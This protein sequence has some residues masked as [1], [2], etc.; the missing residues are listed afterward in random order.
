MIPKRDMDTLLYSDDIDITSMSMEQQLGF[1][2]DAKQKLSNKIE[3][4]RKVLFSLRE[5]IVVSE[6]ELVQQRIENS[7]LV[8]ET[9]RRLDKLL[10]S[11][12]NETNFNASHRSGVQHACD[13]QKRANQILSLCQYFNF[14]SAKDSAA[15]QENLEGISCFLTEQRNAY[16]QSLLY[17]PAEGEAHTLWTSEQIE[18]PENIYMLYSLITPFF[19]VPYATTTVQQVCSLTT[20]LRTL[21][22]F[23]LQKSPSVL[24]GM[25]NISLLILWWKEHLVDDFSTFIGQLEKRQH[26]EVILGTLSNLAGQQDWP[27]S[28]LLSDTL[29][30]MF[31]FSNLVSEAASLSR[32]YD[33]MIENE[34]VW[35][36]QLLDL[37]FSS[38]FAS[39]E[40]I[41]TSFDDFCNRASAYMKDSSDNKPIVDFIK[42]L[43]HTY[44]AVVYRERLILPKIFSRQ[45][46][47]L[48]KWTSRFHESIVIR[49]LSRIM[50]HT[51]I[52][53]RDSKN[54]TSIQTEATNATGNHLSEKGQLDLYF[55]TLE[56]VLHEATC[57]G[58]FVNLV[59]IDGE[60]FLQPFR[61]T[62]HQFQM[63]YS[64]ESS[65]FLF[66]NNALQFHIGDML[67]S[68]G[69]AEQFSTKIG[70]YLNDAAKSILR[71]RVLL[72]AEYVSKSL[73][74]S[75][76][77]I[78][79]S[80]S[81]IVTH[82]F[83]KLKIN[84]EKRV[85]SLLEMVHK[86]T[87]AGGAGL[88]SSWKVSTSSA[89]PATEIEECSFHVHEAQTLFASW[90]DSLRIVSRNLESFFVDNNCKHEPEDAQPSW[91][92]LWKKTLQRLNED[93]NSVTKLF[94]Y[95][96]VTQALHHLV[97]QQSKKD[98]EGKTILPT[99]TAACNYVCS[100][101]RKE[102]SQFPNHSQSMSL[103]YC[104]FLLEGLYKGLTLHV[105]NVRTSEAG[106]RALR[107]D[108]SGYR[109]FAQEV[110]NPFSNNIRELENEKDRVL[111]SF[112]ALFHVKP[113]W[114]T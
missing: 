91:M 24:V 104:L 79:S 39:L 61:S 40:W 96:C 15:F 26:I 29:G 107:Q 35:H 76:C 17:L 25:R 88:F 60:D 108:L 57:Y 65:E 68:E 42:S 9:S 44:A 13:P 58:A 106:R 10:K 46:D 92:K 30:C 18:L 50:N 19:K 38:S 6:K 110:L 23:T 33:S 64:C 12:N 8:Q 3:K 5:E 62:I 72:L 99:C 81:E 73:S 98:F 93:I 101:L 69:D 36:T 111:S 7:Q 4:S 77:H 63:A 47:A 32:V 114:E 83:Q 1:L 103:C 54:K 94:A 22:D 2:T 71:L 90:V 113:Y 28:S 56:S 21:E 59:F 84:S 31:P 80:I 49:D 78:V 74:E 53:Q 11:Q 37:Y 97:K 41:E 82:K 85:T 100:W 48:G 52:M 67:E 51:Q 87:N 20:L 16:L 45:E 109:K 95:A 86:G 66:L 112:D 27:S 105:L 102:V 70:A 34:D 14:L 75:L 55:L 89:T 43:F